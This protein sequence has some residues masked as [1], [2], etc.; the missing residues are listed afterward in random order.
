MLYNQSW[1]N[2]TNLFLTTLG[3]CTQ[4][5]D[6]LPSCWEWYYVCSTSLTPKR[7]PHTPVSLFQWPIQMLR[8]VA[9]IMGKFATYGRATAT[10]TLIVRDGL[11]VD[12][13]IALWQPMKLACKTTTTALLDISLNW[14]TMIAAVFPIAK[15]LHLSMQVRRVTN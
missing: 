11:S 15:F 14:H 2:W 3:K 1:V 7:N 10:R 8:P 4:Y 6:S 5:W 13:A 9:K 12:P